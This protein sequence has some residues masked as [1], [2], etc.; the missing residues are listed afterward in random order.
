LQIIKF[1]CLGAQFYVYLAIYVT[2]TVNKD[3]AIT[4][5]GSSECN[6]IHWKKAI[7]VHLKFSSLY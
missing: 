7:F 3:L 6:S 1:S 5:E 2:I 4:S